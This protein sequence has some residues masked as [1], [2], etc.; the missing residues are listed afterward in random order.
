MAADGSEDKSGS[1][2]KAAIARHVLAIVAV[3]AACVLLVGSQYRSDWKVCE[4]T[5]RSA[6]SARE[7]TVERKCSPASPALA[8]APLLVA[9]LL[10]WPDLSEVELF[11]IG[12]IRR[13]LDRQAETQHELLEGQQAI[14]QKVEAVQVSTQVASMS[15]G[16][17]V[18]FGD[19]LNLANQLVDLGDRLAQIEEAMKKSGGAG[20]ELPSRGPGRAPLMVD[21]ISKIDPW[22]ALAALL[23]SPGVLESVRNAVSQGLPPAQ[24]EGLTESEKATLLNA[25]G[26]ESFDLDG[27]L[28]WRAEYGA[29]LKLLRKAQHP[30]QKLN[31]EERKE[32]ERLAARLLVE[33]ERRGVTE[34]S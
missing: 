18:Q 30:S 24:A 20:I 23:N 5:Q 4:T 25:A 28:A 10:I 17:T 8:L 19:Q 29:Q 22:L 31:A 32:A 13:R 6:K 15:Q 16:V 12:R 2:G 7:E 26:Q 9:L 27:F 21:P 14:L 34:P 1:G 33:L 3:L 11:G